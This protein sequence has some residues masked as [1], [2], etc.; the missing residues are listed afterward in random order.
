MVCLDRWSLMR[1]VNQ[2]RFHC[3]PVEP[4]LKEC[5]RFNCIEVWDIHVLP[6]ISGLSR[7]VVSHGI[8]HKGLQNRWSSIKYIEM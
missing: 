4:V 3:T 8:R 5:P 6:G 2:D 7:Q 1:V